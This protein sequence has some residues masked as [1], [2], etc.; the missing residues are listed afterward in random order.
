[1]HDK[2]I[3]ERLKRKYERRSLSLAISSDVARAL[4]LYLSFILMSSLLFFIF[5]SMY[6]S[7][8]EDFDRVP[9]LMYIISSLS[10]PF[11]LF[12]VT[13]SFELYDKEAQIFRSEHASGYSLGADIKSTYTSPVL[14][15]KILSKLIITSL[16]ILILPY[17]VGYTALA[18]SFVPDL[19]LPEA[20]LNL[21]VKAIM[22]PLAFLFIHLGVFSAHKWLCIGAEDGRRKILA[23][24]H[25]NARLILEQVKILA[26]YGVCFYFLLC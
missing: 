12:S 17:R 19:S 8:T 16:F 9:R 24:R 2:E 20:R 26:I 23:T 7:I 4:L 21:I 10:L 1:M 18:G 14:R 3:H 13:R 15:R 11:S 22:L 5:V 6:E 25:C